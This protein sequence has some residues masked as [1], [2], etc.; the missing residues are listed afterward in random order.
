MKRLLVALIVMVCACEDDTED[1][2]TIVVCEDFEGE[3]VVEKEFI[4]SEIHTC[5]DKDGDGFPWHHDCDDMDS[6]IFPYQ[7]EKP[8]NFK[9]DDCDGEIDESQLT[10]PSDTDPDTCWIF[11]KGTYYKDADCDGE[12][13][14]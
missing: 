9:D 3:I 8:H 6:E 13:D 2:E 11:Y 4:E 5:E 10:N 12:F 7:V 14:A 1:K